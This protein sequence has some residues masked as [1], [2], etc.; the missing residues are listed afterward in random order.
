[1][2]TFST[3]PEALEAI[4]KR[5]MLILVDEK[6]EKEGDFYIPADTVKSEDIITMIRKGG[7]LICTA[8]TQAQATR[9]ALPLMVAPRDN[10]EKT[11]VN[12]TLSVNA[13]QGISMGGVSALDRTKTIKKLADPQALPSE[14]VRPGHVFGLIAK[15]G[16]VLERPGHTEAAID[17]ARLGEFSPAGVLCEIVGEDGNMANLPELFK[18]AQELGLKI[19]SIN[20]LISY[21]KD[22]PLPKLLD[23]KTISITASAKLP[24]K[25][26]M[27]QISV[28][29]SFEDQSEHTTLVK[30][31][32][33]KEPVL[34]RIH[35]QCITG[36]TFG[37]QKC[38]CGEQLEKSL[39]LICKNGSG[40]LLYLNQEGR[41]I[42]LTNKIKAYALQDEGLDTE[43]ANVALHLPVDARDYNIAAE[44]LQDL[45]ICK[46]K[47]LTNNPDKVEQMEAYG[48]DITERVALEIEPN[49]FNKEYLETKRIKFK[50]QLTEV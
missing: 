7:G 23:T 31:D 24:T 11:H 29:K 47:L 40:V 50:H 46:I 4:K 15:N 12:F 8:I 3:I 35:S 33:T 44:I 26:G 16:G 32:I 18:L 39:E 19:I 9:L 42:G 48:I 20:Q 28:Y 41:G 13:K 22:N 43:E 25:N 45:G 1:M 34:V 14:L 2:S 37:S 36:D 17:L 10:T 5:Q 21:V 6:R 30:G 49:K 38:D 27:F